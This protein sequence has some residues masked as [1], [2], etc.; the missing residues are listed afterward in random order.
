MDRANGRQVFEMQALSALADFY[1]LPFATSSK[2]R[3]ASDWI[4]HSNGGSSSGGMGAVSSVTV[5]PAAVVGD[6]PAGM[7][8][9][10]GAALLLADQLK[11]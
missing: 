1:G 5:S 4:S 9:C 2:A 3:A 7:L 11:L 6:Q 10:G 8:P